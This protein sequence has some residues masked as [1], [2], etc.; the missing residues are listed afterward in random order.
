M[1]TGYYT[2]PGGWLYY[3]AGG[4]VLVVWSP[5]TK[6]EINQ[7]LSADNARK[8]IAEVRAYGGYLGSDKAAALRAVGASGSSVS[9]SSVSASSGSA[10]PITGAL[11]LPDLSATGLPG[12]SSVTYQPWFWPAVVGG[13]L[14]LLLAVARPGR[15]PAKPARARR[16]T[17]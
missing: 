14:L 12:G 16:Y 9:A 8:V 1:L 13:G 11:A 10:L 2:G 7:G 15:A 3:I 17:I 4:G 5:K 6:R